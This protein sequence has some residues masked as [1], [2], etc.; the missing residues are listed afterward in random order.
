MHH[1]AY[2]ILNLM[3]CGGNT[4]GFTIIE[5]LIYLAVSSAIMVSVL[6]LVGGSQNKAQFRQA[7]NETEQQINDVI[8]NVSNGYYTNTGNFRCDGTDTAGPILTSNPTDTQGTNAKCVFLG[9]VIQFGVGGAGDKMNVYDAVGLREFNGVQPVDLTEAKIRMISPTTTQASI[10]DTSE[11]R[12]LKYGFTVKKMTYNAPPLNS[13]SGLAILTDFNKGGAGILESSAQ[14]IK[15]HVINNTPLSSSLSSKSFV[16]EANKPANYVLPDDS[17]AEICIDSGT[18]DQH[19]IFK[20]GGAS[21][22]LAVN[23]TI[24]NGKCTP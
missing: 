7:V 21:Q 1:H 9:R 5:T 3:K 13:S 23:S 22:S 18:T 24:Y 15:I 20:L 2:A 14:K 16:D 6:T 12:T 11:K 19:V 8:N 4:Q 17:G 10:P